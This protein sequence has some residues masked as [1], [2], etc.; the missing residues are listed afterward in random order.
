[1]DFRG[2]AIIAAHQS[3]GYGMKEIALY[4]DLYYKPASIIINMAGD[5]QFKT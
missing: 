4:F 2:E 3:E 5:S 1:M